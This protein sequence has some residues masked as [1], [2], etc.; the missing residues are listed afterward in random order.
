M[1]AGVAFRISFGTINAKSAG[2]TGTNE[3][4]PADMRVCGQCVPGFSASF[5]TGQMQK[6]GTLLARRFELAHPAVMALRQAFV[7]VL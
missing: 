3:P 2:D 4:N 6:T 1:G 7:R 5:H